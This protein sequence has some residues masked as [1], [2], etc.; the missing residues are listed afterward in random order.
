M[1]FSNFFVLLQ[2]DEIV[3]KKNDHAQEI[4]SSIINTSDA[5]ALVPFGQWGG[6]FPLLACA[7][8]DEFDIIHHLT[9]GVTNIL[10]NKSSNL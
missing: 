2:Q 10:T 8:E 4:H 5:S 6:V 1:I 3:S 7:G 9:P